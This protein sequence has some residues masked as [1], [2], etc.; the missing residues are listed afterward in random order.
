MSLDEC[1]EIGSVAREGWIKEFVAKLPDGERAEGMRRASTIAT[2]YVCT[3]MDALSIMSYAAEI[4]RF[5]EFAGKLEQHYKESLQYVHP[6]AR[7]V[8]I[9]P[10]AVRAT[11]F[12]LNCYNEMGIQPRQSE[13][14]LV[15]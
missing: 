11:Q 10:G 6:Q 8:V 4:G 14:A 9:I 3:Y 2:N 7:R 12:F 5:N 1:F 13:E 15:A